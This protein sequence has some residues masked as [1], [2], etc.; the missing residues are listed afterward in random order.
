MDTP[1][2]A[3]KLAAIR[4][5]LENGKTG[6]FAFEGLDGRSPQGPVKVARFALKAFDIANLLRMSAL[7]ANPA[8][9]PS[10]DQAAG[11]LALLEGAEIRGLVAPY[12]DAGKPVNIDL[13]SLDWGQFVGPIPSKARL[14]A[15]VSGPLDANDPGQK[16][17]VDRR[18]GP[19]GDQP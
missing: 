6:E 1:E 7:F 4:F 9:R 3:F 15:K 5:N 13:L 10:P 14:T 12:K 11:M 17:L 16:M 8:E 19:G 2:G 18:P